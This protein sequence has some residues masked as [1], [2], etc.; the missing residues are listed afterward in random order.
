MLGSSTVGLKKQHKCVLIH[1]GGGVHFNEEHVLTKA[2]HKMFVD[3]DLY[4]IELPGHGSTSQNESID[5]FK[6]KNILREKIFPLIEESNKNDQRVVFVGFSIGGK[7]VQSLWSE[8]T[9]R[10][11]REPA[12]VFIAA[13]PLNSMSRWWLIK[14][15]WTT[16]AFQLRGSASIM[17]RLHGDGWKQM[18]GNCREWLLP[19]SPMHCDLDS[20][21]SLTSGND[22]VFWIRGDYD[23]PFPK[24]DFE[25][26]PAHAVI[27]VH[28]G[29]FD[30]FS[31]RTGW[32]ET[33]AALN[34]CLSRIIIS[35][36]KQ[37]HKQP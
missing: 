2:V 12:G 22:D 4:S 36:D 35:T 28:S 8:I 3:E 33:S 15:F 9:R 34:Q 14:M 5:V 29:H 17:Q 16:F 10:S 18:V 26:L 31:T 1:G 6:A 7:F 32:K 37:N 24:K 20:M 19:N 13:P 30:F 23:Q 21:K 25:Y 27:S 11:Q